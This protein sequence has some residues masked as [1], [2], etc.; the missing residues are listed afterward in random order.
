MA[1][2][3]GRSCA[4]IP[5]C[6]STGGSGASGS[7]SRGA[8][9]CRTKPSPVPTGSGSGR[10]ASSAAPAMTSTRPPPRSTG[11]AGPANGL[12]RRMRRRP[13]CSSASLVSV[14]DLLPI[15]RVGKPHG[16]DG[17]FVVERASDDPARFIVGAVLFAAGEPATV[18][19]SRRARG[20]PV[21]R[22]DRRV[23]RGAE[24][25]VDRAALPAPREGEYYV[26]ELVRAE[27]EEE[28]GRMLRRGVSVDPSEAYDVLALDTGSQ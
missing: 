16:L 12:R 4:A 14:P 25:A 2:Q 28:G 3:S 1:R 19:A 10:T 8:S 18:V 26:F 5:T 6:S 17:S 13:S 24:L 11:P 20:R 7:S 27:V 21:I 22:L 23:E 9:G 15:G